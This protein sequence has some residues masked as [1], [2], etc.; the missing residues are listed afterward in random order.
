MPSGS[1]KRKAARRKKK[2]PPSTANSSGIDEPRSQDERESDG[3]YTSS[4]VSQDEHNPLHTFSRGGDEGK[5]SQSRVTGENSVEE[6]TKDTE[7]TK[8]SGSGAVDVKIKK[9]CEP[10]SD[11]VSIQH[12][13]HDKSSSSSS[14]S[15]SS[16][17]DESQAFKKKSKGKARNIGS[18]V[19]SYNTENK[20]ATVFAEEVPKVAEN[21]AFDNGGSNSTGDTVAVDN[22]VKTALS[23]PEAAKN[24]VPVVVESGL[25]ANEEKL[26][27]SS[28]GISGVELE[29][30]EGKNFPSSDIPT[31]ESSNVAEANQTLE[32]HEYSEKQPLVSST[33]P[34]VK[35]TSCLGCCGLFEVFTASGR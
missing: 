29:G 18:E 35:R 22:S 32:P 26:F 34:P 19:A 12:V 14:S 9:G 2:Q 24:S 25:K 5:R 10:K 20:S 21:G 13:K 27:P 11:L 23:I 7:S 6:A 8:K 16:S 1:K 31:A 17:D 28:N 33:P 30:V 4:Y 15:R 3:G